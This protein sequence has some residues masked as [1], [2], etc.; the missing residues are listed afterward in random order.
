MECTVQKVTFNTKQVTLNV[1]ELQNM[2]LLTFSNP[3]EGKIHG[4]KADCRMCLQKGC[5]YL[6]TG[7]QWT[8]LWPQP[9]LQLPSFLRPGYI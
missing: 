3:Y 9:D 2:D 4:Y 8:S 1:S 7:C 5:L 6:H